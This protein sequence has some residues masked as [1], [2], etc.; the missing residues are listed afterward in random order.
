[1]GRDWKSFEVHARNLYIEGN[2]G[3]ISDGSDEHVIGNWSKSDP[4][5]TV[6]TNVAEMCS[7]VL[8]KVEFI[9]DEKKR[10]AVG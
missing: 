7:S 10:D 5:Y 6:A 1:M 4:C 9:S 3:E 8:W 2:T